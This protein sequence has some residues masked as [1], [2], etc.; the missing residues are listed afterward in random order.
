MPSIGTFLTWVS[1]DTEDLRERYTQARAIGY[2]VK[3]D[4][5]AAI[6]QD[7][8]QDILEGPRGEIVQNHVKL[9]RDR[10][11]TEVTKWGLAKLF[12]NEYGDRQTIVHG[13]KIDINSMSDSDLAQIIAGDE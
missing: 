5:M 2:Q 4:E 10:L 6:A 12:P 7:D 9:G 1:R 3:F 13:G 11:R 8:A